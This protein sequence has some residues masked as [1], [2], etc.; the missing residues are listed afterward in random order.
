MFNRIEKLRSKNKMKK[1]KQS[2]K[3]IEKKIKS[4]KYNLIREGFY[5]YLEIFGKKWINGFFITKTIINYL[6]KELKEKRINYY[7]GDLIIFGVE[8]FFAYFFSFL[9]RKIIVIDD[10]HNLIE[11]TKFHK[12][13]WNKRNIEIIGSDLFEYL[14][15]HM[16]K[17]KKTILIFISKLNTPL[18]YYSK[19]FLKE[20]LKK[21]DLCIF[22][23]TIRPLKKEFSTEYLIR[24]LNELKINN[25][26]INKEIIVFGNF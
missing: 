20:V 4:K 25:K 22:I 23:N 8:P 6:K 11:F 16:E 21:V 7:K 12:E 17:G 24:K 14:K 10:D 9:F 13:F 18:I 1:N 2:V 3:L 19:P 15:E 26:K 5:F